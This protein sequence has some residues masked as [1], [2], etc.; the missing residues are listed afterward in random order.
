[1]KF[2]LGLSIKHKIM[3]IAVIGILGFAAYLAFTIKSQLATEAKLD[4]IEHIIFP[5]IEHSD[6]A[7]VLLYKLRNELGNALSEEDADLISEAENSAN[8]LAVILKEISS[9]NSDIRAQDTKDLEEAF[10]LY[11]IPAIKLAQD[12]LNGTVDFTQLSTL[13]NNVNQSY[14]NFNEKLSAYREQ[15]YSAFGQ[16]IKTTTE[17]NK[18]TTHIGIA[19]AL[20]VMFILVFS[21]WSIANI[22][23]K[24]INR[25]V[26]SLADM[27]TG[28]GDLTIRLQTRAKDEVG[29][30]VDNFN[31]FIT[32][33][34]LLIKV[35]ANLS[36]GVSSGAEKVQ[37]IAKMT[38]QGIHNQQDEINMVA[39]A[40][41]EMAATAQEVSR[42]ADEAASATTHAKEDTTH[43]QKVMSEN[44]QSISALVS[45]V[46][47]AREVI[48]NL[49]KESALIG[50][51][52]QVIQGIAEQTNL[53]A[54]NA[55]IEAARAGEQ[56]RGFAVV[57][58]EVRSLAARTEESTSEIQSIIERLQHGTEQAVSAMENSREKAITVVDQ[59]QATE[60]SLTSIMTNVDTINDMNGQVANA[61]VE[62]R[63]VSEEVSANIIKINGVSEDTVAQAESTSKASSDL[64]E[65]AENLRQIVN[66]FK[67]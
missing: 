4:T 29:D 5:T 15:S 56:G 32:H 19:I 52:S 41:N 16:A 33:L 50:N 25:I 7:G 67:V 1:M 30:L 45:E 35:M 8:K 38:Q 26:R 18:R 55:A 31:G 24:T 54:L 22:I 23:T 48:Q 63:T 42:N 66:E 36:L 43:S 27:S 39:T 12:M 3:A 13:A 21:A 10:K 57:A 61:A 9:I 28:K 59:S 46:E 2:I 34:Q 17:E 51:A 58:D 53:L 47:N 60:S 62:Q 14:D 37:E 20:L 6:Q 44:V 65:Q 11:R 64:A 40:V 49:A